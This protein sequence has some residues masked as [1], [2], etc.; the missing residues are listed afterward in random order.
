VGA[1]SGRVAAAHAPT[2]M[3]ATHITHPEAGREEVEE[4]ANPLPK[5]PARPWTR[6]A[7]TAQVVIGECTLAVPID[8]VRGRI[9]FIGRESH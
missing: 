3:G 8:R 5:V 9:V 2:T 1:A 7:A 4:V 6:T